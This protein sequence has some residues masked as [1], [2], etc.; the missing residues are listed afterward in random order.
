MGDGKFCLGKGSRSMC[1]VDQPLNRIV[2]VQIIVRRAEVK[3]FPDGK[4]RLIVVNPIGRSEHRGL[5][6]AGRPSQS[7]LRCEIIVVR[8]VACSRKPVLSHG[9]QGTRRGIIHVGAIRGVDPR[10]NCTH[11]LV[12]AS[13]SD[14]A[15]RAMCRS[16][17]NHNYAGAQ[18]LRIVERRAARFGGCAQQQFLQRVAEQKPR[19]IQES[20]GLHIAIGVLL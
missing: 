1:Q 14:P 18:M 5:A 16:R 17:K 4:R 8:I 19:E 20:A 9:H 13:L 15:A 6:S 2:D 7:D 12:P 3:T 10:A 11:I